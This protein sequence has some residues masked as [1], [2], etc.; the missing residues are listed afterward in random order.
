MLHDP[1]P[2]ATPANTLPA[3]P[4]GI[5]NMAVWTQPGGALVYIQGSRDSLRCY[6]ITGSTFEPTP[7]SVTPSIQ[8]YSRI[9][10]TI[11]ADGSSLDTG[12]LWETSGDFNDPNAAG[13]LHAF[14]A[15]DLV[16]ELWNSDMNGG[17]DTMGAIAKFA[18]PT[19]ANGRV[20]VPTFSGRVEIY[21][22]LPTSSVTQPSIGTVASAAS[23]EQD[24]VSPGELVAITGVN[25]GPAN[26]A[27]LTLDDNG[28]VTTSL[29]DT[30]VYFDGTPVPLIYTSTGQVNAI[31]PFGLATDSTQIQVE[32]QGQAS[33][34][35]TMAVA[36]TTPGIFAADGSGAGQG[37]ILNQ[38]GTVNSADNPAAP[39]S[40]IT[41]YIT[42]AG[43]LN[44]AVQDGSVIKPDPP[45]QA[46]LEV[47]ATVGT[48][49]ATVLYAG[50][51]PGIVAGVMQV[52]VQIPP[53]SPQDGAVALMLQAG[54]R[55]TQSG[56][57]L[58]VGAKQ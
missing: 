3:S 12:I 57:T 41:L 25:L 9:G 39:G 18:N 5:F 38:D 10:M 17:R 20:Y 22:L 52:N 47:T 2:G 58:A 11:S 36:Q 26:G 44:P 50:G 34:A 49:P 45:P 13:T 55:N 33:S 1:T 14:Q 46:A 23:Y 32:Y 53:D 42:G 16:V 29:A 8:Q 28:M 43:P 6:R 4:G 56:I 35:V 15:S 24:A 51:A 54:G 37:A 30:R 40:V 21:G 27:S 48:L 7:V 19:V 31:A